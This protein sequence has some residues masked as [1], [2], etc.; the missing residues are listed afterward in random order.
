VTDVIDLDTRLR[1]LAGDLNH[2]LIE[3][4][5]SRGD[6][7]T[8]AWHMA[9]EAVPRHLFAPRFTLPQNL[10]GHTHDATAATDSAQREG[11]LR[12]VYHNEA[13]LT[14]FDS[15]GIATTSCSAP[16]VVA[17]MLESSQTSDRDTVLEIGTG[18]GW[19]AGLLAHRLG[20]DAVTSIDISP[21]CVT[22]ARERLTRLGLTPTLA[23]TD[24]YLGHP[25]RA[26]YDR[27]IATAS[28]RRLP[29]AWLGQTRPGGTILTDLRG[30]FAGNLALLTVDTDTSAHGRFLPGTVHFM[31]YAAPSNRSNCCPNCRRGRSAHPAN[32][33]RP[34]S[35][36]PCSATARSPSSHNWPCQ[37]QKQDTSSTGTAARPTSASP[38][39]AARHGHAS[40]PARPPTARSRKGATGACGTSWKPHTTCGNA[41]D[42][43]DQPTSRS[44]SHRTANK[45]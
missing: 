8:P 38:I 27:I 43:H 2:A 31:H 23:V 28:L 29:L 5:V 9:F 41:Y 4:L 16:S 20:P 21:R 40:R 39:P 3:Q 7:T 24:G 6:L 35:T 1:H 25:A 13:L 33:E 15:H 44:P 17:I 10:G 22:Q 42:S 36:P 34:T 18:T 26:P 12:A 37:E 30:A 14:E 32:T 11:W 19:T 45:S